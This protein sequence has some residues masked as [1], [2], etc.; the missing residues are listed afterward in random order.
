MIDPLVTREEQTKE[1]DAI[2]TYL[3]PRWVV[4][5]IASF[6][7]VTEYVLARGIHVGVATIENVVEEYLSHAAPL[8]DSLREDGVV[9]EPIPFTRSVSPVVVEDDFYTV[10]GRMTAEV[11]ARWNVSAQPCGYVAAKRLY[12]RDALEDAYEEQEFTGTRL[13]SRVGHS[14]PDFADALRMFEVVYEDVERGRRPLMTLLSTIYCQ[15]MSLGMFAVE[16]RW[17][18]EYELQ[19]KL[20]KMIADG[21]ASR[22][23]VRST[24]T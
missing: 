16:R 8:Y 11:V 10:F 18:T 19:E 20:L 12:R 14:R 22:L 2:L 7:D 4:Q 5:P 3:A 13:H 1:R 21:R 23:A 17:G 6:P 15:G 24:T 9:I